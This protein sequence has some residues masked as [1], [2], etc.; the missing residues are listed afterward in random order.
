M[1]NRNLAG[2]WPSV[3]NVISDTLTTVSLFSVEWHECGV[4]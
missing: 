3:I 4:A 2:G 1:E